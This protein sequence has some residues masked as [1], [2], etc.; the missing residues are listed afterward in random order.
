MGPDGGIGIVGHPGFGATLLLG[1]SMLATPSLSSHFVARL[2]AD[3]TLDWVVQGEASALDPGERVVF[4]P[5]GTAWASA[6]DAETVPGAAPGAMTTQGYL[7]HYDADGTLL[8]ALVPSAT[9]R[10]VALD[11]AGVPLVAGTFAD[12]QDAGSGPLTGPQGGAFVAKNGPGLTPLWVR[13]AVATAGVAT[14]DRIDVDA[15][16]RAAVAGTSMIDVG[17]P[18]VVGNG[19]ADDAFVAVLAP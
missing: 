19:S 12:G 15:N 13:T 7:A 10:D 8:E 16:G 3:L 11:P 17:L 4:A 18:S 1:G 14:L 5:D 6:A 9:I 2:E